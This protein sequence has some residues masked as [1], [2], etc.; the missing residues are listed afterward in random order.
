MSSE[1]TYIEKQ[2]LYSLSSLAEKYYKDGKWEFPDGMVIF[3]EHCTQSEKGYGSSTCINTRAAINHYQKACDGKLFGEDLFIRVN[4]DLA[5]PALEQKTE[6]FQALNPKGG[7]PVLVY[8][9]GPNNIMTPLP[10]DLAITERFDE[11]YK[12]IDNSEEKSLFGP[13][14]LVKS[15]VSRTIQA[16]ALPNPSNRKKIEGIL[17]EA[18]IPE[19]E[20]YTSRL[21]KDRDDVIDWLKNIEGILVNTRATGI[22]MDKVYQSIGGLRVAANAQNI[23]RFNDVEIGGHRNILGEGNFDKVPEID[24]SLYPEFCKLN[25]AVRKLPEFKGAMHGKHQPAVTEYLGE[26]TAREAGKIGSNNSRS[27]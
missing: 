19:L 10:E 2:P 14:P 1:K 24:V 3:F 27:I 17:D 22:E 9:M 11:L 12:K 4:V 15:L 16:H 21:L 7:V 13:S 20:K 18:G 6:A 5:P 8:S 23:Y 25:D 26:N